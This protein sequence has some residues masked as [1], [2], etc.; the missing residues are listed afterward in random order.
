MKTTIILSA[1]NALTLMTTG[2][3]AVN[4]RIVK[5]WLPAQSIV[6][7]EYKR[8]PS[9]KFHLDQ[10]LC[11]STARCMITCR[12]LDHTEWAVAG[13]LNEKGKD[14]AK[15][16]GNDAWEPWNPRAQEQVGSMPIFMKS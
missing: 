6:Q 4:C 15:V 2:T 1:L 14:I 12:N 3:F 11:E 16:A 10:H 8:A 7:R 9:D 5:R 13:E